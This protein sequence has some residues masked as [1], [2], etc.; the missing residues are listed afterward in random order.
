MIIEE[1]VLTGVG[2]TDV[3]LARSLSEMGRIG[4]GQM[5]AM[6]FVP[7]PGSPMEDHPRAG[8]ERELKFIAR[9]RIAYP[10][11]LIPASLDLE[12]IA[13]LEVR[14]NAG[15]GVVT[16]IIPPRSG[17]TGVAQP[18]Q[19]VDSGGRTVEEV[20]TVLERLGLRRATNDEF[21]TWIRNA[22]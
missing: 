9:L 6:S 5:R 20:T 4:A 16:S 10:N 7:Q 8:I 21:K 18:E 13:G 2:E 22:S 11:A 19:D 15:A 1:G 14:L 17:L 12:G 3:D